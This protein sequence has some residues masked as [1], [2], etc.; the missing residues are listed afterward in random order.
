MD[1]R[2]F[3]QPPRLYFVVAGVLI[4]TYLWYQKHQATQATPLPNAKAN[5]NKGKGRNRSY[6]VV[7]GVGA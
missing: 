3:L 2:S 7:G 5:G 4:L 6:K 1:L